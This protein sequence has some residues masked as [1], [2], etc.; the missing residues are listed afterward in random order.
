M[1]FSLTHTIPGPVPDFFGLNPTV[2]LSLFSLWLFQVFQ[3]G[4]HTGCNQQLQAFSY[5]DQLT[6]KSQ[7]SQEKS[8]IFQTKV[9]GQLAMVRFFHPPCVSAK[10]SKTDS[11]RNIY[12]PLS[13]HESTKR[14]ATLHFLASSA[15]VVV[16]ITQHNIA[17]Q[18][19]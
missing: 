13:S 8:Q 10:S 3:T 1:Q 19:N 4:G 16:I 9:N 5:G 2:S 11:I 17:A 6:E 15:A 7:I 12:F 18:L 14:R